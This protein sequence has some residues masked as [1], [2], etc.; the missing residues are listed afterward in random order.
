M[1][2]RRYCISRLGT[3][4]AAVNLVL[5]LSWIAIAYDNPWHQGILM[6]MDL[7]ASYLAVAIGW[8]L[9][10]VFPTSYRFVN[11]ATDF[12][13]VAVGAVWFYVLGMI[14]EKGFSK[15]RKTILK[16]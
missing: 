5:S 11:F 16:Q 6:L 3:I 13:F 15:I 12:S 10:V 14:C 2:S 7:P 1:I 4:L 9:G 8:I